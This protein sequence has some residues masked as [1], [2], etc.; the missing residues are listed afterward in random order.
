MTDSSEEQEPELD[1]EL[2]RALTLA[3]RSAWQPAELDP[4]RHERLL[5][6]AL[7]DPLAPPS[8]EEVTESERLRDALEGGS[9]HPDLGLVRALS[10]ATGAGRAT[11]PKFDLAALPE[12]ESQTKNRGRLIYVA[13]GAASAAL[14]AAAALALVVSSL[15][16]RSAP[17]ASRA[18]AAISTSRSS[19]PLFREPFTVE[20]TTARIDRIT[21]ERERELR[22]N[23]Y[24]AWGVR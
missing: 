13:F 6:L 5:E 18:P 21:S 4:E 1:P 8:A 24:V 19:A 16:D 17:S 15:S 20:G 22:Q 10:A 23:R 2:E 7:E 14:A 11:Q 3:L 9:E 12:A